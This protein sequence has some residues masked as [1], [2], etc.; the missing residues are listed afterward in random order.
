M[1]DGHPQTWL[2]MAATDAIDRLRTYFSSTP[3]TKRDYTAILGYYPQGA[4][5]FD[6]GE[7]RSG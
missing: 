5:L 3:S 1:D 4:I 7:V 6:T 2:Y